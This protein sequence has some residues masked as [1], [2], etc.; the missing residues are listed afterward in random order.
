MEDAS[1]YTIYQCQD[2]I[3]WVKDRKQVIVI[4][5]RRRRYFLLRGLEAA[6][7][8]WLIMGC[9]G[10]QLHQQVSLFLNTNETDAHTRIAQVMMDWV[11][12]GIL[13]KAEE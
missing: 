4:S 1:S 9:H 6:I 3:L 2:D 8:G 12:K 7:W 11:S 10:R 13:Q 5:E